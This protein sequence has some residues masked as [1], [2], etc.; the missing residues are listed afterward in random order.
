MDSR[1][2]ILH[3]TPWRDTSVLMDVLC[4]ERGRLRVAARGI[5]GR[6]R[7]PL[8]GLLQ[9][10]VPL[11]IQLNRRRD[12]YYLT[13]ADALARPWSLV[14][15]AGLCALYCNELLLRLLPEHDGHDSLF[16]A[17]ERSLQALS[18]A[19]DEPQSARVLRTF[20]WTLLSEL[21]Y[22]IALDTD[23]DGVTLQPEQRYQVHPERGIHLADVQNGSFLGRDL[24]AF[25]D[26]NWAQQPAEAK[27]LLRQLL[28][29]HLGPKP[30]QTRELWRAR[31]VLKQLADEGAAAAASELGAADAMALGPMS[32]IK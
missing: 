20:E 15:D 3:L 8:A 30:L 12:Y 19:A 10:F 11:H 13:D 14:A 31:Q 5:K 29:S 18:V 23:E 16:D 9:P 28:A 24:L 2:Y 1:A 7:S 17:Y 26:H 6:K 27:R 4:R 25:A 32:P 22:G 21:G